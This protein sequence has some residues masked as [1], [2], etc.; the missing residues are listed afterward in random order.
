MS[1]AFS[2]FTLMK[3]VW[4]FLRVRWISWFASKAPLDGGVLDAQARLLLQAQRL[5]GALIDPELPA[6][7]VRQRF[8]AEGGE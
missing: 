7:Q 8:N 3:I 1:L 4:L 2:P 6:W 5:S